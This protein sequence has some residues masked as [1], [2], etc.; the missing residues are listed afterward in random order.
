[1]LWDPNDQMQF[2]FGAGD[3]FG[4]GMAPAPKP[5]ACPCCC[6]SPLRKLVTGLILLLTL[7]GGGW[8]W[9]GRNSGPET[10][11]V[12]HPMAQP[13]E[14]CILATGS[15]MPEANGLYFPSDHQI[16][17][18]NKPRVPPI[19]SRIIG[20]TFYSN[21]SKTW[22]IVYHRDWKEWVIAT[23]G[24]NSN[25]MSRFNARQSRMSR[26]SFCFC[27]LS[28]DQE[29]VPT[30]GNTGARWYGTGEGNGQ[31][32]PTLKFVAYDEETHANSTMRKPAFTR[33]RGAPHRLGRATPEA[34]NYHDRPVEDSS[35]AE[36]HDAW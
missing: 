17:G 7:A 20:E 18:N 10:T 2:D 25:R 5:A 1:M 23:T 36:L 3:D 4:F 8:L 35:E 30:A 28:D 6:G 34:Y 11:P 26:P 22:F 21:F 14:D 32:P 16:F 12:L 31:A 19:F 29:V 27:V 15:S 33:G 24:R 9:W 13:I